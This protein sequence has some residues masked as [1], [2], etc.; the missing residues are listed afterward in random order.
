MSTLNNEYIYIDNQA[1]VVLLVVKAES[2][3]EADKVFKEK[4]GKDVVKMPW[5]GCQIH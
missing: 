5:V 3:T 1:K 4:I 2:I